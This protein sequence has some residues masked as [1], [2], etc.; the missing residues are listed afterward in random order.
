MASVK[1]LL[2][3]HY[4][5]KDGTC[6]LVLRITKDRKP[7]YVFTG[8][9]ILEKDWDSVHSKIKKSHP[10]SKRLNNFLLKKLTEADDT[11]LE[12]MSHNDNVSAKHIQKKVQRKGK[13][14]SFFQVGS[15]RVKDKYDTGTF[16]VA[17]SELSILYNIKEF[18]NLNEAGSRQSI[19]DGIK[20][21]R[22]LRHK[23]GM[24]PKMG[25]MDGIKEFANNGSLAFTDIDMAFINRFK[26]FCETYLKH[27][28]RTVTNQLIFIR[29]I[30]N[31]AIEEGI[32]NDKYYPFAGDKEKI[33]ITESLKIG[34]NKEEVQ[35]IEALA[36]EEGSSVWHTRNVW[37]FSYYFA[38]VRISDV[39]EM[40]W[41]DFIDDRLFYVMN[42]NQ[43]SQSLKIPEKAR[44][45]LAFY[46]KDQKNKRD[47]IFPFL[48]HANP[49][50]PEDVFIKARNATSL[51]NKYLKRIAESCNIDKKISNHIAR[52]TFGNIAGDTIHPLM[53]QKLYRHTDLKTTIGYQANFIHKDADDAL[54]AVI[55]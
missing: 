14:I 42:K 21:R 10:N 51:F 49:N 8:T 27:K 28:E 13:N 46:K 31:I 39:L 22:Q 20:E 9:Y 41:S 33:R 24:D 40:K 34:L 3:K 19:I 25:I 54:D 26:S 6:P 37:L 23:K 4:E 55:N 17:R 53:L 44:A 29:T 47:Y 16:S 5:K 12:A 1:I 15:K 11:A 43:K 32:V 52:H 36:L 2:W 48:K 18:T 30:Y 35:R 7:R 38:G 45:I 50:N